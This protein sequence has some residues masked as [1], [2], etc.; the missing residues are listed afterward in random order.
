M[1]HTTSRPAVPA[2]PSDLDPQPLDHATALPARFYADPAFVAVDR[3]LIF[4]RGWQLIAHVCQL[5][6]AGDHAVADFAGLP[7]IA[8]RG[9]DEVIRVFHNVCRHRAGPLAQCDGLGA[10]AL[11]CRYHG[12]TY[13]LDGTLRSAPEMSGAPDFN[14]SDVKLPQLA[15]R[16]WQGMVFACV[17]PARA[18]DFDAF[19]AGIDARIG[20]DR[21]LEEYGHHH[22]IGYDVPCNWKVYVDNYLEGYH[23]PHIHPGLNRLLDYRSY[24]TATAE[25]YS[26]Q[27]SPLESDDSLYGS[28]GDALYY[29]LWPNTMLNIVPGRLQTNRI[30]P[31]GADRCRVEFDFYY[32]MDE[33]DA[34]KARR[35][36]DLS[37]SDEVQV[38][39]LTICEDVQRGLSSG[40][41]VPGRLNPLRENAVHHFHELLRATY[42]SGK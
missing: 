26:F 16:V 37:F 5:R 22:R 19:V 21:K 13:T 36:A 9:A 30:L 7:V 11:R 35:A 23:V 25:W 6:N 33:S 15:V 38:E 29:W 1:T 42:R 8:V 34:G 17:D 31:K 39:D 10:K 41:C 32:A 2:P 3:A 40:S 20:P 12:W 27:W 14:V 4:D 18:P 28:G 24:V